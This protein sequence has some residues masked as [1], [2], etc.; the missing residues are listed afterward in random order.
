MQLL[1]S[2]FIYLRV[3]EEATFVYP[4]HVGDKPFT[5]RLHAYSLL[6][7]PSLAMPSLR[8]YHH[9]RQHAE[10]PALFEALFEDH[11]AD[12]AVRERMAVNFGLPESLIV[13]MS[14]I[15]FVACEARQ[16]KAQQNSGNTSGSPSVNARE[17]FDRRVKVVEEQ[18]CNW[19][20]EPEISST[21]CLVDNDSSPDSDA[22]SPTNSASP[23]M[24]QVRDA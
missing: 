2:M 23:A 4:I 8:D 16:F 21:H 10:E 22:S 20:Y 19:S 14:H 13:L 17:D 12:P 3:M 5:D 9:Q 15:T 1:H 7:Y 6:K 18:L 24:Q 11:D